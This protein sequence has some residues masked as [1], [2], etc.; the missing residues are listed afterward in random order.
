MEVVVAKYNE[1]IGW[2]RRIIHP[3]K[4]YDKLDGSLP[5]VGRESETYLRYIIENYP[6]FAEYTVFLQGN[7]FDH[8]T[9]KSSEEFI[10]YIN[11]YN[12]PKKPEKVV[13][14]NKVMYG[15]I[16]SRAYNTHKKLLFGKENPTLEFCSGAQYIVP[17]HCILCRTK[18]F[19]VKLRYVLASYKNMYPGD[20]KIDPWILERL[21]PSIWDPELSERKFTVQDLL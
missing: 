13:P 20:R 15:D 18:M 19:Y 8:I 7:P 16:H 4:I 2:T 5:N 12:P 14:M 6:N 9:H 10:R 1:D 11:S 17:K 21:W 3:I